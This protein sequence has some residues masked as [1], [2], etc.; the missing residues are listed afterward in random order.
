M[1]S[2]SGNN[3]Y[4]YLRR[5]WEHPLKIS[6][7]GLKALREKDTKREREREIF[8]DVGHEFRAQVSTGPSRNAKPWHPKAANQ[9]TEAGA[10]GL[11]LNRIA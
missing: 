1:A 2:P 9:S 6:F 4:I 5:G 3:I 10:P 7:L 11:K 8:S